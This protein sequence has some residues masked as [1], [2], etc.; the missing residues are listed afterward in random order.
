VKAS[1]KHGADDHPRLVTRFFGAGAFALG[2][3]SS[4][5]PASSSSDDETVAARPF[6]TGALVRPVFFGTAVFGRASSSDPASSLSEDD[7]T[8]AARP[9]FAGALAR[10][11][12]TPS[13]TTS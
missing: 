12:I 11:A 8:G 10:A 3:P 9:F 5:D 13:V 1:E 7:A 2:V 6:F 4:S